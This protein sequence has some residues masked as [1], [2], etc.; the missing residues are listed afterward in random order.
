MRSSDFLLADGGGEHGCAQ[1]FAATIAETAF[2]SSG[3]ICYRLYARHKQ[4][5]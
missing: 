3:V 4:L 2:V 1:A 5:I